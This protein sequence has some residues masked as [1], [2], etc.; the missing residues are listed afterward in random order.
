MKKILINKHNYKDYLQDGKL[1][2]GDNK[3]VRLKK[4]DNLNI[5]ANDCNNIKVGNNCNI[6]CGDCNKI[7][8]SNN[9]NIETGENCTIYAD[10]GNS[11]QIKYESRIYINNGNKVETDKACKLEVGSE[12]KIKCGEFCQIKGSE[13]NSVK[14][15]S[16]C[17]V[18]LYD[19]S[20]VEAVGKNIKL[21]FKGNEEESSFYN[22]MEDS[23][24]LTYN[25]MNK[26]KIYRS[27]DL[28]NKKIIPIKDGVIKQE[29]SQIRCAVVDKSD[30]IKQ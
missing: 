10:N 2:I 13:N 15:G 6:E 9:C 21:E 5:I 7:N 4:F 17:E 19:N 24:I 18:S 1:I 23:V 22:D 11:I 26:M 14:I 16:N 12:N 28:L 20:Y 8:S 29:T 3:K 30:M 25:L 27:N